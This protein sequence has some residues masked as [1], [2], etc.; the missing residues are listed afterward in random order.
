MAALPRD[1]G[2]QLLLT[3]M[4]TSQDAGVTPSIQPLGRQPKFAVCEGEQLQ[5]YNRKR[6]G[7]SNL[8]ELDVVEKLVID[9]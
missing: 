5:G 3:L 1:C 6:P 4:L 9:A 2:G 7:W 8:G